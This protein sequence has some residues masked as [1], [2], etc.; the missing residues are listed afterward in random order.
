MGQLTVGYAP[1]CTEQLVPSARLPTVPGELSVS[2]SGAGTPPQ[3]AV[4]GYDRPAVETAPLVLLMTVLLTTSEPLPSGTQSNVL[5]TV[6]VV[7]TPLIKIGGA[8]CGGA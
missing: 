6:T 2:V 1:S 5:V 8:G 3:V 4:T 7:V